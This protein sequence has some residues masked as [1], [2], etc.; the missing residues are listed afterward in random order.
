MNDWSIADF[1]LSASSEF[2]DHKARNARPYGIGWCM[3]PDDEDPFLQ[4]QTRVICHTKA[5]NMQTT[6]FT[7][8]KLEEGFISAIFKK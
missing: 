6:K 3:Q 2:G 8:S 5:P 4:V 1:Q 7:S